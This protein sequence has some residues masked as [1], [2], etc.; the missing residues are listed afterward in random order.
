MTMKIWSN[1]Q[2]LELSIH[3]WFAIESACDYSYLNRYLRSLQR[4][5]SYSLSLPRSYR[6]ARCFVSALFS[7]YV[8][9]AL[10]CFSSVPCVAKCI[11]S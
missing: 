1:S 11:I 2:M 6:S 7:M 4:V 8:H 3:G 5:C 10:L 9:H